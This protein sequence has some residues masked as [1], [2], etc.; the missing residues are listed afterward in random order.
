MALQKCHDCGKDVSSEA[1]SCPNC[2]AITRRIEIKPRQHNKPNGCLIIVGIL[3]AFVMLVALINECEKNSNTKIYQEMLAKQEILKAKEEE[4][5]K[6]SFINNIEN[7]YLALINYYK[8]KN[9]DSAMSTI[10]DFKKYDKMNYKD[11]K[12]IENKVLSLREKLD[13]RT[14]RRESCYQLGYRYGRC[15][16]MALKGYQCDPGDDIIVPAECRG[17]DETNRGTLDGVKSV[18]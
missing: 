10:G 14:S 13:K 3:F 8:N 4:N 6:I 7:H 16:T 18:W 11:V 5:K 9:V 17:L 1:K 2:G 12:K 15:G